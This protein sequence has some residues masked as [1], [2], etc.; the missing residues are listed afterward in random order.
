MVET[1][2]GPK[3]VFRRIEQ[4][5][6]ADIHY[7]AHGCFGFLGIGNVGNQV[8]PNPLQVSTLLKLSKNPD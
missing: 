1:G 3:I 2:A 6:I 8:L 7:Q 4:I 5:Q